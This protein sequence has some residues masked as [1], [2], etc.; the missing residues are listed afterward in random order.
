[1]LNHRLGRRGRLCPGDWIEGLLLGAG[2]QPMPSD[3]RDRQPVEM[4]LCVLDER[5]TRF[6]SDIKFLVDR[7]AQRRREKKLLEWRSSPEA[8]ARRRERRLDR[9]QRMR[10]GQPAPPPVKL[11]VST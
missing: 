5:G 2:Q 1:V 7:G 10:L 6:A 4:R 3:Y 11:E 8:L 9:L